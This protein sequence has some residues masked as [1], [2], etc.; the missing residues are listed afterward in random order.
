MKLK[1]KPSTYAKI[2]NI[3]TQQKMLIKTKQCSIPNNNLF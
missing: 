2:R 3:R 1:F